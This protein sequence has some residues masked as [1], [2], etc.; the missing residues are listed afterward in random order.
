MSKM[1][2]VE[3]RKLN[4]WYSIAQIKKEFDPIATYRDLTI[5]A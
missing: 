5:F 4:G 1:Y 3:G 2:K